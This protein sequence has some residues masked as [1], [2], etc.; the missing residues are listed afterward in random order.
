[1]DARHWGFAGLCALLLTATSAAAQAGT[2]AVVGRV[3]DAQ[4]GAPLAGADVVVVGHGRSALSRS[5][6]SYV[7]LGVPPGT[8]TVRAERFGYAP[9]EREAT[10]LTSDS[11]VVDL[12]LSIRPFDLDELIVTGTATGAAQGARQREIGHTV[13]RV[14]VE[15]RT[16]YKPT[17]SDFLQG[18]AVGIEV[19][20]GSGEASQGKQIRLRGNRGM[21]FSNQP[22]VYVDGI[23]MMESAFPALVFEN[24][25]P[26]LPA[27]AFVTPS[28]LDLVSVGDIERIE[29]VKGPAASTLFGTGSANGV[30]QLFTR[31]G[32]RGAPSWS[33]DISQGTGWVRPFG[34][35]GVDYLNLEHFLRDSWWGGGY[36][37]GAASRPCVTDD[38]RWDHA[39]ASPE[40][41][42][43]WPGAQWYQ[44]YGLSVEGGWEKLSYFV[45]GEYQNDTYALPNDRLE[46]YGSRMNLTATLSPRLEVRLHAAYTDM[47]TA[48]TT[49]GGA[50]EGLLRASIAQDR[51]ILSS[52]D[53]RVIAGFLDLRNDQAIDHVTLGLTST[54]AQSS[55][56]SHR[57]TLGYDYSGQ[58][59]RS[60]DPVGNYLFSKGA[61]TTRTWERR[62]GTA[63]YVAS[64]VFRP[65]RDIRSTLSLGGQ[66]VWDDAETVAATT[67]SIDLGPG[68]VGPPPVSRQ[69]GSTTNLGLFA[70]NVL[71][72]RDRYFLTLGLR[73][74]RHR[75]RGGAFLRADP[76]I[77]A[78][79]TVSDE[80]FWPASL[81]V[82]RLRSAYGRSRS[83]PGPLQ[84]AVI[85]RGLEFQPPDPEAD[86]LIKPEDVAEFEVGLDGATL[87]GRLAVGFS[88]Y[89]QT[90]TNA[91]VAVEDSA[92]RYELQN[93]GRVRNRGIE[94]DIR[95][96]V[97]NAANW[98]VD[99]GFGIT[100]NY[101]TLLD[102]GGALRLRPMNTYHLMVGQPVPVSYGS[103]VA[104]PDAVSGSWTYTVGEDGKPGPGP[105]GPQL[106]THFVIPSLSLRMPF[107]VTLSARGEYRGGNIRFVNPVDVSRGSLS[108]LCLPYYI[109]PSTAIGATLELRADTPD[110]WRERCTWG[111]AQDYWYDADYFKLRE[112][113]AL[114]PVAFAFP[115]A[116]EDATLTVSLANAYRWYRE[117]P[118]WDV[119]ILST[120]GANA[121]GLGSSAR[122]PAPTTVTFAMRVR[123]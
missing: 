88:Y 113:T 63:D 10:A 50:F 26:G 37:G 73:V 115:G 116:V 23:R 86:R 76:M 119:E 18:A 96:A 61:L 52:G 29:V 103:K 34:A 16:A 121:P 27:G 43:S 78:T 92:F 49:S 12:A 39:N 28:P 64:R 44:R 47:E 35:N 3:T 42:C 109:N 45:S 117:V 107:G 74:D 55:R 94:L 120:D 101:S 98:G 22:V 1:M 71:D 14:Q 95:A 80:P 48:N 33:A 62:L 77:G 5:D 70:Q 82:L 25:Y 53:P 8:V 54:F 67:D 111:G 99:L 51:N 32:R 75:T 68:V 60:Q 93:L 17:L 56:L 31:Q 15:Q 20:G 90:T 79:W 6:G 83:A 59:L 114:I 13:A 9:F 40:G 21:V 11:V 122:V 89:H 19:T 91:L 41:A 84:R 7:I 102:L 118:W 81:G 36:E 4:S 66:L 97:V 105:L 112:V 69:A 38:P 100:T 2:G 85:Y 87:G 57:L 110:L 123:F 58:D 46:R 72:L 30:I 24:Y 65:G 106:P 108:P 104:D